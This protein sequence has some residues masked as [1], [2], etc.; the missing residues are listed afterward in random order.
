[1]ALTE[2][3]ARLSVLVVG[4]AMLDCLL[5][6]ASARLCPE[7][8]VPVV[9]VDRRLDAP[10]GAANTAANLRALGARVSLLSVVG[11]DGEGALLRRLLAERGVD[12][13]ALIAAPGRR[14]LAKHRVLAG[15]QM[16]VR[17]DHGTTDPLE[18]RIERAVAERAAR[19]FAAHDAVVISDY[20]YGVLGPR[21]IRALAARQARAPRVVVADARTLNSYRGVGVTAVK[22]NFV[23]AV[24][25][26]GARSR[27]G[28]ERA[29]FL[30]RHGAR[31]LELTGARIAAVT[32]DVDG[33]L[34]LERGRSPYRTYA[35]PADQARAAGAGDTLAAALALALAA[36]AE[37]PAAAEL[38]AAAA[39]VVVAKDGTAVCSAT[40]LE[41]ALAPA[42]KF[43]GDARAL[44]ACLALHRGQGRRVVLAS[45]C[46]D[47][48]HP[49]HVA[50][51]TAAKAQG[52]VLIVGLNSD[53]SVARLKGPERPINELED[54]VALIAGLSAVDHIVAF[55]EDTPAEL[56]QAVRP[57]VFVKGGDYTRDML[58]EAPLVEALGGQVRILP[59]VEARSTTSLIARIRAAPRAA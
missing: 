59:Y 12:A 33:A 20:G 43:L 23:E 49:G 10:G 25:L 16:L 35:R 17:F 19:L 48:L 27:A 34:F 11:E 56:L 28:E 30:A 22:P 18:A 55:D 5:Q 3:F 9:A 14:T 13:S 41:A 51:L 53:A 44:A 37:L 32:L 36:G 40:E 58:P 42:G 50:F 21:V 6:G 52:D 15:P 29:A 2:A 8:P 45:G 47:L 31:L 54:R 57:D 39:A 7:A 38:A 4:D 26:L 1:M 46:F 24:R